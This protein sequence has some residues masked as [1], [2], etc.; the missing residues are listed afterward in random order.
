VRH[1]L[2]V[3]NELPRQ[4]GANVAL[5]RR[6]HGDSLGMEDQPAEGALDVDRPAA[7]API[8]PVRHHRVRVAL[9]HARLT[10]FLQRRFQFRQVRRH[11]RAL[12]LRCR[13]LLGR[14]GHP[15]A[16]VGQRPLLLADQIEVVG[17]LFF[18]LLQPLLLGPQ[19][20][21]RRG[22]PRLDEPELAVQRLFLSAEAGMQR[23]R[24][25]LPLP[26]RFLVSLLPLRQ[27][28]QLC[29]ARLLGPVLPALP[30]GLLR[31]GPRR[32][33]GALVDDEEH[34]QQRAHRAQQDGQEREGR[35]LQ[36]MASPSHAAFP[37]CGRDR[38][39]VAADPLT[40]AVRR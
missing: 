16:G 3:P 35:D 34:Q 26:P 13:Q 9:L 8:A 25:L 20:A 29:Q 4:F 7:L 21:R 30:G 23:I 2:A 39:I 17:R 5:R 12:L 37:D 24:F 22:Q 33:F 32:Q 19:F 6:P 14:D 28:R 38:G 18:E 11:P 36:F 10:Q 15:S 40:R 31:L 1:H 27:P